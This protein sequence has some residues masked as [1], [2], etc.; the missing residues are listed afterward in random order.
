MADLRTRLFAL[1]ELE[2]TQHRLLA[3]EQEL[4]HALPDSAARLLRQAAAVLNDNRATRAACTHC[5]ATC[6]PSSARW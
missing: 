3:P 4:A 6:S 2:A 1:Q 5:W